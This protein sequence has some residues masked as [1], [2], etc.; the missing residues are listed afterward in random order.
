MPNAS[1]TAGAAGAP[2]I[3]PRAAAWLSRPSVSAW[4]AI[5]ATLLFLATT[6][7][8]LLNDG[9]LSPDDSAAHQYA[10]LTYWDGF[11]EGDPFRWFT[12]ANPPVYPPLVHLVGVV[13]MVFGGVGTTAM[14][15]GLN[16]VFVPAL[17]AGCYGTGKLLFD[18]RAGALAVIFALSTPFT[19]TQFHVFM[20]DAPQM[21]MIALSVWLLLASRQFADGRMALLAGLASGGALMTKNTSVLFLVGVVGVMLLRGGWRQWR[22]WA[23]YLAGGAVIAGPWYAAHLFDQLKFAGGAA[24]AGSSSVTF[25]APWYTWDGI[26]YYVWT[27]I[28]YQLYLPMSLL[29]L[30]GGILALRRILP[31][32]RPGDLMPEVLAGC[33]AGWFL[34]TLMANDDPRYTMGCTVFLA[35]LA[36]GWLT[37]IR[38]NAWRRTA[39]AA[40]VALCVVTFASSATG[41]GPEITIDLTADAPV[42]DERRN[43]LTI[44]Y[45]TGF[46]VGGPQD[47]GRVVDM[48][49]A[50]RAAGARQI[51]IDRGSTNLPH[52]TAPGLAVAARVAGLTFTPFNEYTSLGADDVYLS[53]VPSGTVDAPPCT[54]VPGGGDVYVLKGPDVRPIDQADNL[55]CPPRSPATY[56]AADAAENRRPD[57]AARR[58]R[59]ALQRMLDAAAERG[60]RTV[61]FED[62][63]ASLPAFGGAAALYEQAR[64]AGLEPP[65][66]GHV[67]ELS[68]EDGMYVYVSGT[69]DDFPEP[70]V[71]LPDERGLFAFLGTDKQTTPYA[72]NLYCPTFGPPVYR[73]PLAG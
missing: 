70:C 4:V 25:D 65:P 67:A 69:P 38:S 59:A 41:D 47:G 6:L 43:R 21:A 18:E 5:G 37:R 23:L 16:V 8:W 29:A 42:G 20:L 3:R 55:W 31:R 63:V 12:A 22:G 60:V 1:L 28:N 73:G 7:W 11:S 10:A 49:K 40:V 68:P 13:A 36:T 2:R 52:F 26:T 14:I 39:I 54:V 9:S 32:P 30:V 27:A 53:K 66:G 50:A 45:P 51:A 24:V 72:D 35:V 48:L 19:V 15:L 17:A 58:Q 64:R 34:T 61:Y 44:L 62:S 56:Q 57:A 71:Q 46:I 33:V